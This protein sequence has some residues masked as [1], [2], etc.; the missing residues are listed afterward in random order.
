VN[1]GLPLRALLALAAAATLA[2]A[3]CTWM[4]LWVSLPPA[5]G[6]FP[7]A[8]L[9]SDV[10]VRFD[11][12]QRPY[13]DAASLGDALQ[14]QGWLHASHRLWQMELLRRAGSGRL[15]A[16]LGGALLEADEELWRAGVPQLAE[17]LESNSDPATLA[18]ID[19]YLLGVNA[20]IDRYPLLPPE[21]LL[22]RAERPRWTRRDVFSVGALTA[23]QSANNMTNEMLRLAL[24][25]RLE[26]ERM[27]VFLTDDS[28]EAGYPFVMPEGLI[29]DAMARAFDKV[30]AADPAY[31]PL[32]PRLGFGSNGWVVAGSHSAEGLPLYAFDSHDE[33]GLPNLF[34]EVHL[35]PGDG[36]QVRGWSAP[37]LPGVINGFN[38]YVA[39]GFT[40]IG[41]T[42]DLFIE[43]RSDAD[44][45]LFRDGGEWYRAREERIMIEVAGEGP[46]E[47]RI[48]HTRNGPLVSDDPPVSLAWSV[49]RVER[50][51]L[52]SLLRMNRAT[53]W[54]AF[55]A[56][57][58]ELPAPTLNAT[59]ADVHGT[60]GFRT[61]GVI[62]QRAR[63]AGLY[64]EEGADPA[65]RWTGLVPT[66][67]MPRR[68]DP[69]QGFLAAANA[70]VNPDG[71]GP[72]VSADNAAPYRIAR[73]RQVL[74][75]G[76]RTVED[77]R[78]LQLDRSDGQARML[79]PTL[80]DAVE[81]GALTANGR[82]G[83]GLLQAWDSDYTAAPDSGA[84]LLFQ[85][86]YLSL[87][88]EIFA[89]ELGD[90]WP[91]LLSRSYLLNHALDHLVL[92]G[93]DSPWWRERRGELVTASLEAAVAT[94]V[95]QLGDDLDTWRL[96]DLLHVEM[97]HAL[98]GA[99]PLL[100]RL[101]D[102]RDAPW[103]GGPS[104]V[105]RAG[106]DFR[107]PFR[108]R[109]GATVR[110]IAQMGPT[111]SVWA[112]MPGGQSGHPLSDHY[113]DQYEAWLAGELLPIA[114]RPADVTG[115]ALLF[116]PNRAR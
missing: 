82:R 5:E 67:L 100:D 47:L 103:G 116:T 97:R 25:T 51:R 99:V 85:Q 105:G 32:V 110:A 53:G 83:L 90:L 22:L 80:L 102:L 30:T 112:V 7:M 12:W 45:L 1:I 2:I 43:E 57:L 96:D 11:E 89:E 15:A 46:H 77:M 9:D 40:N 98:S 114:A 16:L 106:Y 113:A 79:L 92:Y 56:A 34:Y 23:F 19:R 101:L 88:E 63:G 37:G 24:A 41:D 62:P 70:R 61:A 33:L 13:I 107:R 65:S 60:I 4:M 49:H 52:D 39:W 54:G 75:R 20:A 93:G 36:S 3:A 55:N 48:V 73:I 28:G 10:T 42:Q 44:P 91:R 21:F 27:G 72:L 81:P 68:V 95:G 78:R 38:E 76:G 59:Y 115:P 104:T 14:V 111:P 50:P 71:V 8:G 109:A 94:L 66:A 29:G 86:W 58:D 35:F 87:A 26:P 74:G 84:A 18:L 6:R 17:T 31:N 64:P 108:V 69:A